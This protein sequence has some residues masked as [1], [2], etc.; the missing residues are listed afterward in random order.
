MSADR[1]IVDYDDAHDVVYLLFLIWECRAFHDARSR[2]REALDGYEKVVTA[3]EALERRVFADFQSAVTF[4]ANVGK[5]LWPNTRHKEKQLRA[6]LRGARL[7]HL[8][9]IHHDNRLESR[10]LRN[11]L[12][13]FD[14]YLDTWASTGT[15]FMVISAIYPYLLH[16]TM[17]SNS[18]PEEFFWLYDSSTFTLTVLGHSVNFDELSRAV[19]SVLD[20]ALVAMREAQRRARQTSS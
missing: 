4:A 10:N 18:K 14:E 9:N 1:P 11:A 17:G 8:L 20:A 19:S 15:S 7:R 5:M 6:Q 3:D 16:P 13:H 12:E 2:I